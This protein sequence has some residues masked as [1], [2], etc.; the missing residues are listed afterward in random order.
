MTV[1]IHDTPD[2]QNFLKAVAGFDEQGG[3][4]RAKQVLHRLL[5]DVYRL[6]DDFDVSPEE[7]WSAVSLLNELGK[8]SQFGLL[9]PGLGFDHFL[10]MRMDAADE[11]AGLTGGTPRTI[12][13]PLYVAGA[14]V[15]EGEARMDDGS[16]EGAEVMWL[17]GQVRDT[18]GKPVAGA[19]VEIW[20]AD[21]K[22]GY[23]FF[24]PSQS[25]YN[26]RRTI[27]ADAEGRYRARSI[28]P[29]GYGVPAGSPTDQVLK[30]LGR[31]GQRP[32]HIHF[33]VSAPGHRHLTTQI[34]LAGDEYT[35]DDF[36]FATREEL[37]VDATRIEEAAEA[38]KRGLEAPFTEVVFDVELAPT[39]DPE[40]QSRHKRPRALEDEA[41]PAKR[42]SA[43]A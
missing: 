8:E 14:P 12:E 31:H 29:S 7:F 10:D 1:K 11:Q 18:Q 25:Q 26:L 17:T 21:S 6:I 35:W 24:D 4:H 20:H 2:V 3:S 42:E 33:F 36:A 32:A 9:A 41:A 43:E 5:S 27:I 38:A 22:G 28:I 37:V 15:S 39:A 19:Q 34:N 16:D 13:G 23:S 40:Q 30:L